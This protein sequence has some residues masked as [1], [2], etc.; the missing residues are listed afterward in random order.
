M[1]LGVG[2]GFDR[3]RVPHA[4]R[5]HGLGASAAALAKVLFAAAQPLLVR[6]RVSA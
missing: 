3:R 5:A 2:L 4:R 6:V 1:G